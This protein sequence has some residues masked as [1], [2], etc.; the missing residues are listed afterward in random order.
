MNNKSSESSLGGLALGMS[1]KEADKKFLFGRPSE[2]GG[3]F[4]GNIYVQFTQ[5]NSGIIK[6]MYCNA[7]DKSVGTGRGVHIGS[8]YD[9]VVN[10]YGTN[11]S[12][13]GSSLYNRMF[14]KFRDFD[15]FFDIDNYTNQVIGIGLYNTKWR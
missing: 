7:N 6:Y 15:L 14:Y 11:Y 12:S 1:R 2:R 10:A 3:F 4:Y 5:G 8:N 9:E 13:N